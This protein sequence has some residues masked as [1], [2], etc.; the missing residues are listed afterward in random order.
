M[1]GGHLP[2]RVWVWVWVWVG[3]WGWGVGWGGEGNSKESGLEPPPP[4]PPP[5][6]LTQHAA[7]HAARFR[8][9]PRTFSMAAEILCAEP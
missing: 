2:A 4:P 1:Q 7:A 6:A 8:A 5:P 9:V 3:G